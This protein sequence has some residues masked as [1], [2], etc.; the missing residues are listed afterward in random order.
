MKER[1]FVIVVFLA[2]VL[3]VIIV[4]V[5]HDDF[6]AASSPLVIGGSLVGFT[7]VR[8]FVARKSERERN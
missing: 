4:R 5:S 7:V 8:R 2:T 1:T 6:T 3:G